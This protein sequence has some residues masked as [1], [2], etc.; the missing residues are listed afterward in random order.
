MRMF[1]LLLAL[2]SPAFAQ[3]RD[4]NDTPGEWVITHQKA[5]G[6][7][8][9]F[10]D[11]RTTGDLLEERCYLRYVE[12][13]SPRPDFGAVFAFITPDGVE[14]GLERSIRYIGDGLHVTRDGETVWKEER[15][16]CRNGGACTLEGEDADALL[17]IF[18]EGGTLHI[19]L[20]QRNT[21]YRLAWDL[22]RMDEALEDYRRE[23]A[24][25]G[26]LPNG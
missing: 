15:R 12:V 6:L 26:L 10:C 5:F 13:Y 9:S 21:E 19:D 17:D 23:A 18:A 22:S 4:G 11:E 20:E 2:A 14:F 16:S 3:D 1:L 7:W 25:R 24:A 8:D